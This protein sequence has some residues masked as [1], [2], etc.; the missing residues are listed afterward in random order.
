MDTRRRTTIRAFLASA[1]AV[2]LAIVVASPA[3]AHGDDESTKAVELAQQAIAYLVNEPGN[4]M[5]AEEKVD[6]A[7]KA[8]DQQG[9]DRASLEQAE[10]ALQRGNSHRGRALLERAIGARPH[11]TTVEPRPIREISSRPAIGAESGTKVVTEP[12]P[13]R[14]SLDRGAWTLLI[15]SALVAL[16]GAVAA[17]QFRPAHRRAH[18]NVTTTAEG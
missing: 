2:P 18:G 10:Q 14:R 11:L 8:P 12:L 1:L 17:W 4:L 13:G 3:G 9:V 6:D 16:G 5:A 15:A 7:L